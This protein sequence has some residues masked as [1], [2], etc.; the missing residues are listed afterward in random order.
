MARVRCPNN[1]QTLQPCRILQTGAFRKLRCT[2]HS[3]TD[4]TSLLLCLWSE[5]PLRRRVDYGCAV[6]HFDIGNYAVAFEDAAVGGNIHRGWELESV[7]IGQANDVG[8]QRGA[9]ARGAEDA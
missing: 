2:L 1:R 8:G 4:K 9:G 5:Y 7:A 6:P 3:E